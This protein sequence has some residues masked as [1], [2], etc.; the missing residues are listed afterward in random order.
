MYDSTLGRD[1][2]DP[3]LDNY[4]QPPNKV[5]VESVWIDPITPRLPSDN[6]KD[7]LEDNQKDNVTDNDIDPEQIGRDY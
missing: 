4:R 3:V 7:D 2:K 5:L 6:Q 1:D